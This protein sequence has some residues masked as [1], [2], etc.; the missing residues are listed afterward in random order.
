MADLSSPRRLQPARLVPPPRS[1]GTLAPRAA[2]REPLL[3][4]AVFATLPLC[5]AALVYGLGER[6]PIGR[7]APPHAAAVRPVLRPAAPGARVAGRAGD[8]SSTPAARR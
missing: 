2:P 1:G 7:A 8:A 6:L 5:G 4:L 3:A